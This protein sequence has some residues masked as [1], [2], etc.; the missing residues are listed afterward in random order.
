MTL[1]LDQGTFSR[2]AELADAIADGLHRAPLAGPKS[3]VVKEVTEWAAINEVNADGERLLDAYNKAA[4]QAP[5]EIK[6]TLARYA[7]TERG[8]EAL[9][10]LL[11][12]TGISDQARLLV[13]DGLDGRITPAE[14]SEL[15]RLSMR[16]RSKVID[17]ALEVLASTGSG[18][19][20]FA[21][22]KVF[23][24]RDDEHGQ[25]ARMLA[26]SLAAELLENVALLTAL[27]GSQN[28]AQGLEER[29]LLY[30]ALS[31]SAGE[32]KSLAETAAGRDL[33]EKAAASAQ[34]LD[35]QLQELAKGSGSLHPYFMRARDELHELELITGIPQDE[36]LRKRAIEN[37]FRRDD[38]KD[39]ADLAPSLPIEV[40]EQ[41]ISRS[42]TRANRRGDRADRATFA[43][44]V[45][46]GP[47]A[48]LRPQFRE[49]ADE[50]L[51][52]E[53][54]ELRAVAIR[55]LALDYPELSPARRAKVS[56]TYD[57]LSPSLQRQLAPEVSH[58]VAGESG[59]SLESF[60]RAIENSPEEE[61]D[62]QLA[63]L[64]QRWARESDLPPADVARV[65]QVA[66]SLLA[67]L[68]TP[69]RDARL[70][71]IAATSADWLRAR[72]RQI[73][74]PSRALLEWQ[75][76]RTVL[77][78][79]FE[80]FAD[81][82]RADQA[83]GLLDEA[84]RPYEEVASDALG[85]VASIRLDDERHARI[86][87][88]VLSQVITGNARAAGAAFDDA[89]AS[90]RRGLLAAGLLA[91]RDAHRKIGQLEEA[92]EQG[93]TEA[94]VAQRETIMEALEEA[95]KA[96]QG[97]QRLIE[98]FRDIRSVIS[99]FGA[100]EQGDESPSTAVVEWRRQTAGKYASVVRARNGVPLE[101]RHELQAHQEALT[102]LLLDLDRR[103]HSTRGAP[104][105]DRR[106]Y[107]A[108]VAALVQAVVDQG[109]VDPANT[110]G[111]SPLEGS[112]ER[113][114]PALR[115]TLWS[116][117]AQRK[118]HSVGDD[119]A[120]A[121]RW[122]SND[123]QGLFML[124]AT[125][126]IAEIDDLRSA[127]AAFEADE[128]EPAWDRVLELLELDTR[129]VAQLE[130][131]SRTQEVEIGERVADRL[132]L[133]FKVI[134]DFLFSYFRLRQRLAE[135]GW[136]QVEDTL[137]RERRRDQLKAEDHEVI[138]GENADRFL[139]R[140]LGIKYKGKTLRRAVVEG[141]RDSE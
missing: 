98:L 43:L 64:L 81:R 39:V 127:V 3:R 130:Q 26:E 77:F 25:R 45:L 65:I 57:N 55:V 59:M 138:D 91:E 29:E 110:E 47:A 28:G 12:R 50:C 73:V 11:G 51:D 6:D 86:V 20:L 116:A 69:A 94:L 124:E 78:E 141:R 118:D 74:E 102:E 122:P 42:L 1:P 84:L 37:L 30:C 48:E 10:T 16:Q 13:L 8:R 137:G 128:V 2:S 85:L 114:Q 139:V 83:R 120:V 103:A 7:A 99:G 109:L 52:E 71:D 40:L 60:L 9:V 53:R 33:L 5:E 14:V 119:L 34:A 140:S 56:K 4:E 129:E 36:D 82:L 66:G 24:Q 100:D 63:R 80:I 126:D 46:T 90:A 123:V 72:D 105:A 92:L 44:G 134:E 62:A 27:D 21:L 67:R 76:F 88:P 93:A 75:R 101:P 23:G 79:R 61:A 106:H 125:I 108:D 97:N 58:A 38:L 117:W 17:R 131:Q 70:D 49:L 15:A 41:Y 104:L 136:R 113:S 31:L 135:A 115:S 133:S 18:E 111:E 87:T 132:D 96:G 35:K 89:N 112:L 68:P 32:Q 54:N 107:Q 121:L 95:E 19:A 22:T